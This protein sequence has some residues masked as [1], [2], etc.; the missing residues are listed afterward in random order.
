[1]LQSPRKVVLL[2]DLHKYHL[3]FGAALCPNKPLNLFFLFV[4]QSIYPQLHIFS[5]GSA[6]RLQHQEQEQWKLPSS[7]KV[8][9]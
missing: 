9:R 8:E 6:D 3:R 4:L 1:M 2:M 5:K 7:V